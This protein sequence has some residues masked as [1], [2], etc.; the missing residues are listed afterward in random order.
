M[1]LFVQDIKSEMA[2]V[3]ARVGRS[4]QLL[5]S[6]EGEMTRWSRQADAFGAQV[7][8]LIGNAVVSSTFL[9]YMG[10]FDQETRESLREKILVFLRR[11]KV[12]VQEGL[13]ASGNDIN[14]YK[15][16]VQ[17]GLVASG[18]GRIPLLEGA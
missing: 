16:P 8:T 13:V 4:T 5:A 10:M 14:I 3:K 7:G 15:V 2:R 18:N 12:P 17:E 1:V 9:A 11:A 6:L